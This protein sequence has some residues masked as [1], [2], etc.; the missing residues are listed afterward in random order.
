RQ[1]RGRSSHMSQR[2][3]SPAVA[4][5]LASPTMTGRGIRTWHGAQRYDRKSPNRGRH[6][7]KWYASRLA[8]IDQLSVSGNC[9][10]QIVHLH[11]FLMQFFY[12]RSVLFFFNRAKLAKQGRDKFRPAK[13]VS[14]NLGL[15]YPARPR[16]PHIRAETRGLRRV[17]LTAATMSTG[18]CVHG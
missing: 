14:M 3:T 18:G 2:P 11:N 1:L 13:L 4:V 12:R 10:G 8:S 17:V 6:K 15:P 16:L 7:V 9:I 5:R